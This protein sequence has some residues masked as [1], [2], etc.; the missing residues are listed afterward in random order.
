VAAAGEAEEVGDAAGVDAVA[1]Q[2]GGDPEQRGPGPA[3]DRGQRAGVVGIATEVGVQVHPHG[4]DGRIPGAGPGIQ[5]DVKRRRSASAAGSTPIPPAHLRTAPGR[6]TLGAPPMPLP[7]SRAHTFLIEIPRQARL[8]YCLVRDERVPLP[9]KV[10]LGAVLAVIVSPVNLPAWL[11]VVGDLDAVALGALA[12]KVFVDACPEHV[13]E[14]HRLAASRGESRFDQDLG[15]ALGL[16]REAVLRV[17]A[18][19]IRLRGGPS[20]VGPEGDDQSS[21]GRRP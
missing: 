6:G 18:R 19:W 13:V 16:V 5:D 8:A 9:S 4:C 17:R 12:V 21:E 2:V 7:L 15:R 3:E 11:P 20:G 1:V 14:E 10:A